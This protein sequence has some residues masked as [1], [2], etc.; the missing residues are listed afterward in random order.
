[1]ETET[2]QIKRGRNPLPPE[3]KKILKPIF[4]KPIYWEWLERLGKNPSQQVEALIALVKNK[5]P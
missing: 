1:M 2:K 4:L 3:E 5:K